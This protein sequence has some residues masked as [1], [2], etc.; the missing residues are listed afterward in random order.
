VITVPSSD[1]RHASVSRHPAEAHP[2]QVGPPTQVRPV[3]LAQLGRSRRRAAVECI[4]H[5]REL[6]HL[7]RHVVGTAEHA[8]QDPVC[9][10]RPH[11]AHREQ[12]RP[13]LVIRRRAQPLLVESGDAAQHLAEPRR[14][15][16]IAA[17]PDQLVLG[18]RKQHRERGKRHVDL[19]VQLGVRAQLGGDPAL[20]GGGEPLGAALG[21][22]EVGDA[23]G[24]RREP[25]LVQPL[26]RGQDRCHRRVGAGRGE[27]AGQVVVEAEPATYRPLDPGHLGGVERA[28]RVHNQ[29]DPRRTVR[30]RTDLDDHGLVR[31][32][33]GA[34]E[35]LADPAADDHLVAGA[36]GEP[37]NGAQ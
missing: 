11:A 21:Q 36:R 22:R 29:G 14:A 17:E 13:G 19:A 35:R 6:R 31:V 20:A 15:L 9:G 16:P 33:A 12:R 25:H 30:R 4:G 10:E 3:A 28:L 1:R 32:C 5:L 26:G 34:Q 18:A 23:L 2:A 7:Q 27:E 37:G 8:Q 24:Q